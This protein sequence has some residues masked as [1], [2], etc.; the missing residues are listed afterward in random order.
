MNRVKRELRKRGMKLNID[1]MWLPY[2]RG[3]V[4]IDNVCVD[5]E[6][7]IVTEYYTSIT[8]KTQLLRSGELARVTDEEEEY[9]A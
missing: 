6:N 3:S 5:S 4:T 1:Y 8:L 7:A 9:F 2:D